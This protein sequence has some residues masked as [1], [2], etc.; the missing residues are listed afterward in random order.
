MGLL[1]TGKFLLDIYNTIVGLLHNTKVIMGLLETDK[2]LLDIYNT[3]L[4]LLNTYLPLTNNYT[5]Y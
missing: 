5:Y 4:I 2:F 3:K 1:E